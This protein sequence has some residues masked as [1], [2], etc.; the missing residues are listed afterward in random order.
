MS[1]SEASQTDGY[2]KDWKIQDLLILFA[3]YITPYNQSVSGG[4][5]QYTRKNRCCAVFKSAYE[6]NNQNVACS[7]GG[8]VF[9]YIPKSHQGE[10]REAGE[11]HN[12]DSEI[13]GI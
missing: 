2:K 5:K 9:V 10:G 11:V 7:F 3:F 13:S 6:G 12:K 8:D 4:N 1:N